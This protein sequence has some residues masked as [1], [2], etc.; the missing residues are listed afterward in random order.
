MEGKEE[1]WFVAGE[2][3]GMKAG[4][5]C[6][7][8]ESEEVGWVGEE[9]EEGKWTERWGGERVPSSSIFS[10]L[11]DAEKEGETEREGEKRTN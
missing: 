4:G 6:R 10:L 2:S 8:R 1:K 7:E 5:E 11:Q 3:E 9:G